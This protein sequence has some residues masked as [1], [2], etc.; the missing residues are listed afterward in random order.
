M[1]L[2]SGSSNDLLYSGQNKTLTELREDATD[3]EAQALWLTNIWNE[4]NIDIQGGVAHVAGA[5]RWLQQDNLSMSIQV[6]SVW[7]SWSN[8]FG[9]PLSYGSL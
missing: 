6:S 7:M 1:T 9:A 4:L 8:G 2:S 5:F 3:I